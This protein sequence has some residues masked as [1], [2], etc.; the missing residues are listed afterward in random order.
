MAWY[1]YL[2]VFMFLAGG[3]AALAASMI[4]TWN[5]ASLAFMG[6]TTAG[7]VVDFVEQ[8]T[9]SIHGGGGVQYPVVEFDSPQGKQRFQ[10]GGGISESGGGGVELFNPQLNE[11]VQVVYDPANPAHAEINA[12]MVLWFPAM[13]IGI[14]GIVL[15]FFAFVT[16]KVSRYVNK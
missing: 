11:K 7:T 10:S 3:V 4:W 12:F 5:S 9:R 15:L 13:M 6:R 16:Y 8:E 1:V 2:G 14:G